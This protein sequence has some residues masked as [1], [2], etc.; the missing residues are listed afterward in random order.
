MQMTNGITVDIYEYTMTQNTQN[1]HHMYR[2]IK[3][4]FGTSL[5]KV[6]QQRII[7]KLLEQENCVFKV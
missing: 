4:V 7:S 5:K 1:K 6:E 3:E 2:R